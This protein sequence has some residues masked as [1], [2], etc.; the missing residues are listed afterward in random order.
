MAAFHDLAPR[1]S[2]LR[3]Q[4]LT[5]ASDYKSTPSQWLKMALDGVDLRV[6]NAKGVKVNDTPVLIRLS[7]LEELIAGGCPTAQSV[8]SEILTFTDI[9]APTIEERQPSRRERRQQK[10]EAAAEAVRAALVG[11]KERASNGIG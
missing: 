9:V 7:K 10:R 6:I 5:I 4:G 3:E 8:Q 2:H 11:E 1:L